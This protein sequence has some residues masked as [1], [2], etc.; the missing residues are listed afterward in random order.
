M[1]FAIFFLAL[2]ATISAFAAID[3]S[4]IGKPYGPI[5]SLCDL[6]GNPESTYYDPES[7]M[8]F[9]SNVDGPANAKDGKGSIQ[10]VHSAGKMMNA[11]WIT[12][13]NAPKGMRAYKGVLWVSDIDQ[14]L[15]I[16][17]AT[18][19]I[20]RRIQVRGAK[21]LNDVAID[22][23]GTVFV[24]DML[25]AKI[26]QIVNN[27]V[28]T[29]FEGPLLE[30]PNGL[31]VQDNKLVIACWGKPEADF[32]TKV[33]GRLMKIDLKTK[34]VEY[35]TSKPLGNLDGLEID[36]KGNYLVSDWMAGKVYSITP[37]GKVQLLFMGMKGSADIGFIPETQTL[38][39]PRMNENQ[40]TAF[41]MTKYPG[42]K[43]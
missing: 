30:G 33:A 5:W 22:T 13:L 25:G 23:I 41:D 10:M 31:L 12:G 21:F 15:S 32:S 18:G 27:T 14:V 26:Y 42:Y 17:I 11:K 38:V 29:F 1:R 8:L 40:I 3:V 2:A 6:C 19:K 16:D 4:R 7:K 37:A 36:G 35:V 39:I 24:S 34:V 20:T 9:I 43:N 28:G